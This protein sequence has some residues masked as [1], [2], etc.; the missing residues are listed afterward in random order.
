MPGG[1]A[2]CLLRLNEGV[3]F[4]LLLRGGLKPEGDAV[5]GRGRIE[6]PDVVRRGDARIDRSREGAAVAGVDIL[7]DA[8]SG[9]LGRGE[10]GGEN[11]PK[12]DALKTGKQRPGHGDLFKDYKRGGARVPE[13]ISTTLWVVRR[14]F[15]TFVST[16]AGPGRVVGCG[17]RFWR[18]PGFP[19]AWH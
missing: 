7:S 1:R 3:E 6:P 11:Y 8:V 14:Q 16:A 18:G 15:V 12:T 4:G 17:G 2:R 19:E 5:D 9:L 13:Q 10:T